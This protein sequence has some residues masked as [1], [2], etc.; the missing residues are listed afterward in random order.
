[1][2]GSTH[3]NDRKNAWSKAAHATS[4]VNTGP[5]GLPSRDRGYDGMKAQ[6]WSAGL[7]GYEFVKMKVEPAK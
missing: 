1:M 4:E 3:E 5:D 6:V 2:V 7:G